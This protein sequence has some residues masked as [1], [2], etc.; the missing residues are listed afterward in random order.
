MDSELNDVK[1]IVAIVERGKADK[2]VDAAKNAGA[3]ATV[4]MEEKPDSGCSFKGAYR[5]VKG[6]YFNCD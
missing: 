6:N 1:L 5:S 4:L 3:R 2:I